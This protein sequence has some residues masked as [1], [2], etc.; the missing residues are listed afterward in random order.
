MDQES[1][2]IFEARLNY[3]LSRDTDEFM[4]TIFSLDKEYDIPEFDI[5]M[6]DHVN[7][8][9]VIF[10]TGKEGLWYMKF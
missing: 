10:G 5:F 6:K 3:L 4:K 8:E 9:I 2:K 7:K 1:K